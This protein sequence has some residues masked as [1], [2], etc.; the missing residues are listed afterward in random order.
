MRLK[1]KIIPLSTRIGLLIAAATGITFVAVAICVMTLAA[2]NVRKETEQLAEANMLMV[3]RQFTEQLR[4]IEEEMRIKAWAIEHYAKDKE[5]IY[6]VI[7][8]AI[9]DKPAMVACYVVECPDTN[10]NATQAPYIYKNPQTGETT[11]EDLLNIEDHRYIRDVFIDVLKG[12]KMWTEPYTDTGLAGGEMMTYHSVICNKEGHPYAFIATDMTME[13]IEDMLQAINSQAFIAYEDLCFT[14]NKEVERE[15]ARIAK[16]EKSQDF[17]IFTRPIEGEKWTLGM[18]I[19]KREMRS[20]LHVMAWQMGGAMVAGALLLV[21]CIIMAV[22]RTMKPVKKMAQAAERFSSGDLDTPMPQT[23]HND[24]LGLLSSTL[25]HSRLKLKQY[26]RQITETT[27]AKGRMEAELMVA[28]QLQMSMLKRNFALPHPAPAD[29]YASLKPAKE[30]GGDFYDFVATHGKLWFIVGDVSGKGV[31]AAMVM[32]IA[33]MLFRLLTVREESPAA[34]LRQINDE[35][36]ENN[37][38]CMFT[39]AFIGCINLHTG[40]IVCSNAGHNPPL[41]VRHGRV[42]QLD[43]AAALPLGAMPGTEYADTTASLP[44]QTAL[45]LYT[46][47][48]NEAENKEQQQLGM[49]KVKETLATLGGTLSAKETV[50]HMFAVVEDFVQGAMQSDDLTVMCIRNTQP[51]APSAAKDG[52]WTAEMDNKMEQ[53]ELLPEFV[54]GVATAIGMDSQQEMMQLL[55]VEEALVNIIGHAYAPH[56]HDRIRIEATW[57]AVSSTLTWTLTDH[58]QPFDPT[59]AEPK[60][61]ITASVED[62]EIGGL[63]LYLIRQCMDHIAYKRHDSSNILVM[64]KKMQTP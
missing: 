39:T 60:T 12:G 14:H 18:M 34:I 4:D 6:E 47:G 42:N 35:M 16:G 7:E 37:E 3:E 55:A 48:L 22:K 28:S 21:V 59:Q 63:G 9:K 1:P 25:E 33:I 17:S 26:I 10:A 41:T 51:E 5:A 31:P 36:A 15:Y 23:S 58:G 20:R 2:N 62:R 56:T 46:D 11:R 13:S 38:A 61:D 19:P 64:Q 30:V 27:E 29:L 8:S 57:E 45:L 52:T 50:N 44:P 49:D 24:E 40:S 53:T 32:S 43:T 54:H